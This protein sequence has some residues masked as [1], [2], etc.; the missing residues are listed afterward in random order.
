MTTDTRPVLKFGDFHIT[1][2]CNYNCEGCVRM[3]N[4]RF[5]GHQLWDDYKDYYTELSKKFS[6]KLLGIS[7]GEPFLNPDLKNWLV[8]LRQ[9]W[10]ESEIWCGT[11]GSRLKFVND[12]YPILLEHNIGLNICAH[13][14]DTRDEITEHINGFLQ[15]P[16]SF[17]YRCEFS[18][19]IQNYNEIQQPGW[20]DCS[21]IE[22]FDQL[23]E[24]IKDECIL[25]K[26][27]PHTFLSER[28]SYMYTDSNGVRVMYNHSLSF[29]TAS[30]E[31][32]GSDQ[33]NIFDSD[34]EEAHSVCF[35]R[36]CHTLHRGKLYK[37]A[38]VGILP[39]F[40]DQ[41]KVN[42]SD[43]DKKLLMD[44]KPLDVSASAEETEKFISQI[45]K[46]I[47]QCKLCPSNI[48]NFEI[49]AST[50]KPKIIKL[51]KLS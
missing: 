1:H 51:K 12:L 37:C 35:S 38:Q 16:I 29:V 18:T 33:F 30:V 42:I 31:Y 14:R 45:G 11:N 23:P 32:I 4:Y 36:Y 39:E 48:E 3:S 21:S 13:T 19:W 26:N 2:V 22:E 49:N 34:P 8:G 46:P 28:G 7:G 43:E 41:Y 15:G 9:L 25:H 17:Q 27:D 20:P 44:Y 40:M 24:Y 5:S 10:P 6:I 50:D 47:P